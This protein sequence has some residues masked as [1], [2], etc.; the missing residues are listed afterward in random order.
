MA[1]NIQC[2]RIDE[3]KNLEIP[4]EAIRT[5][6]GLTVLMGE[7]RTLHFNGSLAE[8]FEMIGEEKE[9]DLET[10]R[11]TDL[12]LANEGSG[13]YWPHFR[14]MMNHSRG[15]LKG[16]IIWDSCSVWRYS[17]VDGFQLTERY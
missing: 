6:P 8:S 15:T 14:E 17:S 11:I 16:M 13:W 4:L 5:L 7:K 2:F 10:V 9:G 3:M 1:D 12:V